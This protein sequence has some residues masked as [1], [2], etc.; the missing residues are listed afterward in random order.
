MHDVEFVSERVGGVGEAGFLV[1]K[2]E[3][4]APG[5][6]EK[7]GLGEGSAGVIVGEGDQKVLDAMATLF[8]MKKEG[9]IKAV[10]FSGERNFWSGST[11]TDSLTQ[12][13]LFRLFCDSLD[14]S[15]SISSRSTSCSRTAITRSKTRLSRRSFPSS[16]PLASSKSSPPL[17]STWDCSEASAVKLGIPLRPK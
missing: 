15:P 13:T 1:G 16:T 5:D 9:L 2:D 17:L 14:S 8:E 11:A 12:D 3:K 7:W 6:L 4:I 10:G